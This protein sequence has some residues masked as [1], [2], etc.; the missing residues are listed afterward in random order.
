[1]ETHDSEFTLTRRRP[2]DRTGEK[3]I[4]TPLP[5][6][7]AGRVALVTGSGKD[8]VGRVIAEA[9]ADHGYSLA[10]HYHR[11]QAAASE[12]VDR[13][14][15]RGLDAAAFGADLSCEAEAEELV[16]QVLARFGRIDVL[17]NSAAIYTP[18]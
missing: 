14:Q 6:T 11:S 15:A 12:T 13:L 2:G 17:V 9:L 1:M 8:R 7:L 5:P 3:K 16:R 18:K 4:A 10:V